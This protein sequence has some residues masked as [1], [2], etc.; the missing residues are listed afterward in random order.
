M[1]LKISTIIFAFGSCAMGACLKDTPY[2]DVA[3]S[4]P[5]IE[6][7]LSP[8]NGDFG[9][10]VY[11]GDTASSPAMDTAVALVIASPQVLNKDITVTVGLDTSQISAYNQ[12][13]G[14]TYTLLPS[15]LYSLTNT[16]VTIKAGYRV[17]R[18]SVSLNLPSFNATHTYALPL[19]ITNG[20]GLIISGNSSTFMWLFTRK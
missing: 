8:A 10:F 12:A 13:N 16:S 4:A 15:D 19:V 1:N 3:N 9:P 5:I 2:L 18:L 17:G 6:F 7:G 11:A 20:G 14:T